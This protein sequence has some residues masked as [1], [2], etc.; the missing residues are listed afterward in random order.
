MCLMSYT[1]GR[2]KIY[3]KL[4]ETPSDVAIVKVPVSCVDIQL[5]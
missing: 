4:M 3:N 2:E 1:S 5:S